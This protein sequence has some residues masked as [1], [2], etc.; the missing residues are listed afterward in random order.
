MDKRITKKDVE[1]LYELLAATDNYDD[2]KDLISDL[3]SPF[4]IEKMIQRVKVA[5][6]LID[7]KKYDDIISETG[8][9]SATISRVSKC[10]KQGRGYIKYL[11]KDER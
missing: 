11:R 9:S 3:C 5:K 2:C 10:I 7:G 8:I 1:S 4:E 6:L